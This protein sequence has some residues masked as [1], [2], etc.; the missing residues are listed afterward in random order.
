LSYRNLASFED[1]RRTTKQCKIC[2]TWG[3]TGKGPD[4]K[5]CDPRTTDQII[6]DNRMALSK[7]LANALWDAGWNHNSVIDEKSWMLAMQKAGK[8]GRDIKV[9]S[10]DTRNLTI[11]LLFQREKGK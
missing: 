7:K 11:E 10:R 8:T 1:A 5:P 3:C 9:P 2:G 4:G 6:A